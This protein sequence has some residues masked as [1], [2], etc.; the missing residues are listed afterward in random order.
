MSRPSTESTGMPICISTFFKA[1]LDAIE[2]HSPV[3]CMEKSVVMQATG[4]ESCAGS[5]SVVPLSSAFDMTALRF[6][7]VIQPADEMQHR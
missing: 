5:L 1:M 6:D 4:T 3:T 7:G 2:L